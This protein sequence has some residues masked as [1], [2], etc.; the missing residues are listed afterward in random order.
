MPDE[1][2]VE[3]CFQFFENKFSLHILQCSTEIRNRRKK[4]NKKNFKI[5]K[6]IFYI[7]Y[8]FSFLEN[9]M[10]DFVYKRERRRPRRSSL[11]K[12]TSGRTTERKYLVAMQVKDMVIIIKIISKKE[13]KRTKSV[14][15]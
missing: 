9:G 10:E 4:I 11:R 1:E 2:E 15:Q 7:L 12:T 13:R 6:L 5:C 8:L 3:E 14:V